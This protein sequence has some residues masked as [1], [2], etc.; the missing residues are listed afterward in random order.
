MHL[1]T[2][3]DKAVRVFADGLEKQALLTRAFSPSLPGARGCKADR[4]NTN[5]DADNG[6]RGRFQ[7]TTKLLQ[8]AEGI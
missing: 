7:I 1:P 4:R 5:R 2:F 8:N 6:F 3:H